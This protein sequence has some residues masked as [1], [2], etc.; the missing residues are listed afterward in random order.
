VFAIAVLW[1]ITLGTYVISDW[2]VVYWWVFDWPTECHFLC[3]W[4]ILE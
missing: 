3:D 1:L 2:L 4:L